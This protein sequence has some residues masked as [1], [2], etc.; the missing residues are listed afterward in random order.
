MHWMGDRSSGI[1]PPTKHSEA[2]AGARWSFV[3]NG[4]NFAGR[5]WDAWS[6]KG[7]SGDMC[8]ALLPSLRLYTFSFD[9]R[10]GRISWTD[11]RRQCTGNSLHPFLLE[12][13][14]VLPIQEARSSIDA[15]YEFPSARSHLGRPVAARGRRD[16]DGACWRSPCAGIAEFWAT[17]PCGRL[18]QWGGNVSQTLVQALTFRIRFPMLQSRP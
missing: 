14:C 2:H 13:A 15:W 11:C 8:R 6:M 12:L 18:G 5:T 9:D 3:F 7:M 16:F 1:V 4:S 10:P 17:V